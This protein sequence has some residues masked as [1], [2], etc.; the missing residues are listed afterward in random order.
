MVLYEKIITRN[1]VPRLTNFCL[2]KCSACKGLKLHTQLKIDQKQIKQEFN[3]KFYTC[4]NGS[5][6]LPAVWVY[7]TLI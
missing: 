7:K 6:N 2:K 3:S 1:V 4:F 5:Q